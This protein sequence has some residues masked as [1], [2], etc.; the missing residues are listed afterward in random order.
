MKKDSL[1]ASLQSTWM[2]KEGKQVPFIPTP[3]TKLPEL[4]FFL[5]NTPAYKGAQVKG[6][7][8][9]GQ[10]A[11]LHD[12][13]TLKQLEKIKNFASQKIE[14]LNQFNQK[15]KAETESG[16]IILHLIKYYAIAQ[17]EFFKKTFLREIN[18][19]GFPREALD[20][21]TG[22]ILDHELIL[23]L[24]T[25]WQLSGMATSFWTYQAYKLRKIDRKM[26]EGETK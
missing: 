26:K 23:D 1:P 25:T 9:I 22:A 3:E 16:Y 20:S 12:V 4:I 2:P 14:E 10:M 24:V 8:G 7:C 13:I 6:L 5:I 15:H 19:A 17:R 11:Y 18:K 21:E